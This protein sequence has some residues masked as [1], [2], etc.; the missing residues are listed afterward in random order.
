MNRLL[1]EGRIERC[2]VFKGIQNE[3]IMNAFQNIHYQVK[4]YE[5]DRIIAER[6]SKCNNLP[7]I[8]E[9]IVKT[10]ISNFDTTTVNIAEINAGDTLAPAFLFGKENLFPV[11]IIA[12]TE[13][14]LLLIPK[15]EVVKLFNLCPQFLINF[16]DLISTRT[17]YLVK[18]MSYLSFQTLKGKFA[19]YLL[20]L[21]EVQKTDSLKLTHSQVELA[22]KFGVTRPSVARII[23]QFADED[24]ITVKA[25]NIELIDKEKISSFLM[26]DY[27]IESPHN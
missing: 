2:K 7:V 23:K 15:E 25:K 9:G 10:E 17:Q 4:T 19:Y 24:C 1:K 6:G 3:N 27:H 16:L 13:V 12:K 20:N 14:V 21:S 22:A 5:K 11:D 18:K 26:K 8:L